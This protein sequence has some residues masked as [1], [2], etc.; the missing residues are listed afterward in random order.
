MSKK[1]TL[2]KYSNFFKI[3]VK[4]NEEC[5]KLLN[6]FSYQLIQWAWVRNRHGSHKEPVKVYAASTAS[7]SEYRFH[8]NCLKDFVDFARSKGFRV[9]EKERAFDPKLPVEI[10]IKV[11]PQWKPRD[12][13]VPVLDYLGKDLKYGNHLVN[14]PTGMGKALAL[15]ALVR[16]KNGWKTMGRMVLGDQVVTRKGTLANVIGV[17]PQGVRPCY[18]VSTADGRSVVC[19]EDHLWEVYEKSENLHGEEDTIG[20]HWTILTTKQLAEKMKDSKYVPS[21]PR[22]EPIVAD[23]DLALELDPYVMG[24]LISEGYANKDMDSFMKAKK[25]L[26][27]VFVVKLP[28]SVKEKFPM[29]VESY[30]FYLFSSI[31]R[32][33]RFLCLD[34][35]KEFGLYQD[36]EGKRVKPSARYLNELY[37]NGSHKQR[38]ELLKGI[39]DIDGVIVGK[40]RVRINFTS[41]LL[42]NQVINLARSLGLNARRYDDLEWWKNRYKKTDE[43]ARE[44]FGRVKG[45]LEYA[46][47][48]FF[49]G[50]LA[51]F[52]TDENKQILV[53]TAKVVDGKDKIY[54]GGEVI[55]ESGGIRI[56]SVTK[57]EDTKTQCITIDD[58]E[59]LFI[60]NQY[61]VTHNSYCSMQNTANKGLR[62]LYLLRPAFMDKWVSDLKNTFEITDDDIAVVNGSEQL[63]ALLAL[64]TMGKKVPKFIVLSNKTYQNYLKAYEKYE[65]ELLEQG[66]DCLPEDLY[67]HLGIGIRYIDEVHL[68]FHLNFKSDLYTHVPQAAAFSAS[69]I[70]SD[71][72]MKKVYNIAYPKETR[73]KAPAAKQYIAAKGV[74][75]KLGLNSG[76]PKIS[77]PGRT[78]YSHGAYEKWLMKRKS[79]TLNY[80]NMIKD[81]LDSEYIRNYRPGDRALVF[82]YSINMATMLTKYLAK[83]YPDKSVER[84]VEDD[85]YRNVMEPDIRVSTVLSAG[86]G[87]DI[88]KLRVAV[89]TTAISSEKSNIQALGRIRELKDDDRDPVFFWLTCQNIRKHIIYHNGKRELFKDRTKSVEDIYYDKPI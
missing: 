4:G 41:G 65:A 59:G 5:K 29:K 66:Y 18:K 24:V 71:P 58:P 55:D 15:N 8:I 74:L 39:F 85:A 6:N 11:K 17:Y 81:I 37:L 70:D 76:T 87:I 62:T 26:M 14:L 13:Q 44:T 77:W 78:D 27:D 61:M 49:S 36:R 82:C 21:I 47:T 19:D 88:S 83:A 35:W 53:D 63:M 22:S 57:V 25:E 45:S 32:M 10:D 42:A 30:A 48:V 50:K 3:R 68:D 33:D 52:F 43:Q 28:E 84:Y 51:P 12:Y 46:C 56:A 79:L 73:Y 31:R 7:R 34:L 2:V 60:T 86:T 67:E 72:F 69:L 9:T 23:E 80:F 64:P 20:K 75:Y 54:L 16:V 40:N 89:L 38:A 1:I